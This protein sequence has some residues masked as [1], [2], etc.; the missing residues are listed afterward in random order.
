M[1]PELLGIVVWLMVSLL[2]AILLGLVWLIARIVRNRRLTEPDRTTRRRRTWV[3]AK[4]WLG[5]VAV[6][7][8]AYAALGV[9]AIS[10]FRAATACLDRERTQGVSDSRE[11]AQRC[12]GR[13]HSRPGSK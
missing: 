13:V 4:V 3:A 12:S 2:A 6:F 1:S 5:A 8:V 9:Y 10:E 7:V 11:I